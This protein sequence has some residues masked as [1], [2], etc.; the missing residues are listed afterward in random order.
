MKKVPVLTLLWAC[1]LLM[2]AACG[3][4]GGDDPSPSANKTELL[5][6]VWKFNEATLDIDGKPVSLTNEYGN[7]TMTFTADGKLSIYDPS[8]KTTT[9]GTWKFT[10]GE[11]NLSY[12]TDGDTYEFV[13]STLTKDEL[14]LEHSVNMTNPNPTQMDLELLL[15]A[16][17]KGATQNTKSIKVKMKFKP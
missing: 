4:N 14:E 2:L 9:Q 16:A 17:F 15:L 5:A 6:R 1:A 3:K 8:D 11:K 13:I 7:S 10:N 12:T